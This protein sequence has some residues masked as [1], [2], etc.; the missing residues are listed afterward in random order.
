MGSQVWKL[1]VA[2]LLIVALSGCTADDGPGEATA[3]DGGGI[4]MAVSQTC[5]SGSAPECVSVNGEYV[6]V[7]E[8]D[9]VRAGVETAEAVSDGSTS[10]IDVKFDEDGAGVFQK[11]TAEAA[12]SAGTARLVIKA[13]DEVVSAVTVVEPMQG[14]TAVIAL[15]PGVNPDELAGIIRGS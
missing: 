10:A 3:S 6:M 12:K 14:D 9:F 7:R 1:P 2:G 8:A 11:L 5:A 15:P 4:E 13:G